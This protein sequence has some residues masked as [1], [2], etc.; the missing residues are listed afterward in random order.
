MVPDDRRP[1]RLLRAFQGL[2]SLVDA[3][4]AGAPGRAV[5]VPV[6]RRLAAV[7]GV[8]ELEVALHFVEGASLVA[9]AAFPAGAISRVVVGVGV[10]ALV[11]RLTA[12][13]LRPV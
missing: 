9:R 11:I 1:T 10:A 4:Q 5:L 12:V 2:G 8:V 6:Q 3:L 13:V 7:A